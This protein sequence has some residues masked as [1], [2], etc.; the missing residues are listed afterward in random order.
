VSF[1]VT[2][3]LSVVSLADTAK[4][5]DEFYKLTDN[6][7][8]SAKFVF[9]GVYT[10]QMAHESVGKDALG[11]EILV[12]RSYVGFNT[13]S[14]HIYKGKVDREFIELWPPL[15]EVKSGDK[16]SKITIGNTY[17]VL[18]KKP[19]SGLSNTSTK[20]AEQPYEMR[21]STGEILAIV[22]LGVAVS[23]QPKATDED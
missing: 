5:P 4:M 2:L 10:E 12:W 9:S 23:D 6:L 22:D 16:S 14:V 11:E 3:F 20:P 18:I 8:E 1:L 19:T 15:T 21:V 7:R 17:L 13:K